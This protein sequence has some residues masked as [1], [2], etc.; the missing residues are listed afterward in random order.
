MDW[1][2]SSVYV[3][4]I[5]LDV[6]AIGLYSVDGIRGLFDALSTGMVHITCCIS[7]AQCFH[8]VLLKG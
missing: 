7:P 1:M 6:L 2:N 4:L 5:V 8:M 3:M